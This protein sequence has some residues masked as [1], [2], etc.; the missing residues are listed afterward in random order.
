MVKK[1]LVIFG[2]GSGISKSVAKHFGK[3]GFELGIVARNTQ[4]LENAVEELKDLEIKA[5]AF[6]ADLKDLKN[7]PVLINNI[8]NTLGSVQN[9]LWNAFQDDRGN[10][11]EQDPA[12][13]T[14][15]MHIRVSSYIAMVQACMCDLEGNQGAVMSTNGILALDHLEAD[16]FAL[17]YASLAI[18]ATAQYKTTNI[19]NHTL[20]PKGIFVGQ[21]I[22]NGFVQ[23]TAGVEDSPSNIH[24]DTIA[25][26]FWSLY[27]NKQNHNIIVGKSGNYPH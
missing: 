8:R 22:V 20:K 10:L 21:V 27:T 12:A 7:I 13:L 19:L 1:T 14:Q 18:A 11:I 26:S 4:N 24:P 2:Y 25:E 17:D 16:I 3:M 23:G 6:T 9:I 15:A 5:H